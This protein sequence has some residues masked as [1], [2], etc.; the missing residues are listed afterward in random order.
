[1]DVTSAGSGRARARY[2]NDGGFIGAMI[3]VALPAGLSAVALP[4]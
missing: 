4:G 1:M 3:A 2:G